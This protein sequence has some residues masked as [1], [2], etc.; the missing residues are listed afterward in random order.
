[1]IRELQI[2]I[3]ACVSDDVLSDLMALYGQGGVILS[4][5]TDTR[6][7]ETHNIGDATEVHR[8]GETDITVTTSSVMATRRVLETIGAVNR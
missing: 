3:R 4:L 1:M 8:A 7:Y 2:E 5:Q 6:I